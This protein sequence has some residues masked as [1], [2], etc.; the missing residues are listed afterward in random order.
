M[1]RHRKKKEV[2]GVRFFFFF[3]TSSRRKSRGSFPRHIGVSLEKKRNFPSF[4]RLYKK[5][6][7]RFFFQRGYVPVWRKKKTG[8]KKKMRPPFFS[9]SIRSYFFFYTEVFVFFCCLCVYD[10]HI[11][12]HI[13][14]IGLITWTARHTVTCLFLTVIAL[15]KNRQKPIKKNGC[16]VE[17]TV[18]GYRCNFRGILVYN[19]K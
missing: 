6:T 11:Y 8:H 19:K 9:R 10:V 7:S 18:I 1:I 5:F 15:K 12:I 2:R 17:I 4:A 14:S 16:A 3:F 13:A